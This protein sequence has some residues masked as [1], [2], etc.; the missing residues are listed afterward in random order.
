[1]IT[2]KLQILLFVVIF[3]YFLFIYHFLRK[4]EILLK[5][6]LTWIILGVGLAVLVVFPAV[7]QKIANLVGIYTDINLLFSIIMGF[8]L[9]V[10]FSLTII[11]SRHNERHKELTQEVALLEERVRVLEKLLGGGK[12]YTNRTIQND[13]ENVRKVE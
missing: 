1:M 12:N 5:Y 8:T 7:L 6:S 2:E 3:L 9:I 13:D 11:V 4:R 10:T